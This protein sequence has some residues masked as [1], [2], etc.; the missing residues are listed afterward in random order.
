MFTDQ[1]H[2]SKA[3][4]LGCL[5]CF[6]CFF[7]CIFQAGRSQRQVSAMEKTSDRVGTIFFSRSTPHAFL[8]RPALGSCSPEKHKKKKFICVTRNLREDESERT[9]NLCLAVIQWWRY[10]QKTSA[11]HADNNFYSKSLGN[12]T[13]AG[14][15]NKIL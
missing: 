3:C 13:I 10:K 6:F 5:V 14:D 4:F 7:F 2:L 9:S 1:A 11:D 12:V 15:W 8:V